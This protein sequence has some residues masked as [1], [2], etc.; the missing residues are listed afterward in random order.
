MLPI[1]APY[2]DPV[3]ILICGG[4]TL[5]KIGLATCVTITPETPNPQWNIEH[6]VSS[7]LPYRKFTPCSFVVRCELCS[8]RD[9][10]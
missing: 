3:T 1:N 7:D 4:A 8:L 5:E 9:V 10:Y 6:M 2:T